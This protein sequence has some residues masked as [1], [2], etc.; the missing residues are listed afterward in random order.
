MRTES[1]HVASAAACFGADA[2]SIIGVIGSDRRDVGAATD[3]RPVWAAE[4]HAALTSA[5]DNDRRASGDVFTIEGGQG[6]EGVEGVP[7]KST[8][9][10]PFRGQLSIVP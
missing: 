2:I 5:A 6:R 1:A 8:P 3:P 4:A 10:E 9:R 7:V